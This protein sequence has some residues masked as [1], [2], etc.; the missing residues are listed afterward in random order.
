VTE[1]QLDRAAC[2]PYRSALVEM[3]VESWRFVRLFTRVLQKVE[4]SEQQRY[5][6]QL[7]FHLSA[8]ESTLAGAGLRLVNLEGQI[9]DPG[10]AVTVANPS[11]FQPEDA[12]LI[13]QM[14]EPVIMDDGGLVRTGKVIL[15]RGTQCG[16]TSA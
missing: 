16:T 10:M 8:L 11:D 15:G 3:G 5:H 9:F 6:G 7:R 1:T 12:P 13:E 14:L 4:L 2:E